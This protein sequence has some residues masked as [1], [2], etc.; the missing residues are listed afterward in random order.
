MYS[1][2]VSVAELCQEFLNVPRKTRR[3]VPDV[4]DEMKKPGEP[5]IVAE[6]GEAVN[7]SDLIYSQKHTGTY[8]QSLG[9]CEFS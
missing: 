3:A 1:L 7:G 2:G 5:R 6:K 9:L 4:N 8:A